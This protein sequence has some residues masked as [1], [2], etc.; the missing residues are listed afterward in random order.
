MLHKKLL[1]ASMATAL[2]LGAAGIAHAS[3]GEDHA[4]KEAARVLGAK[5]S[6][7]QA[8][9]TAENQTGGRAGRIE[10]EKRDGVYLYEIK[11]SRKGKVTEVLVDPA[12]G[13]VLESRN[14]GFFA[15]LFDWDDHAEF[16][17]L[18]TSPTTL[19]TAIAAAE[20][21]GGGKAFEAETENEH[22]AL[23]FE[24][25]IAKGN[26]VRKVTVDARN[27]QIIEIAREMEGEHGND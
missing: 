19:S 11:L 2:A 9:A 22:D 26:E 5:T 15:R 20:K 17:R 16:E 12:S 24:V 1:T 8:I 21:Q 6:V 18:A 7:S 10:M 3:S 25:K 27:G 23:V 13:K 4:L 14:E